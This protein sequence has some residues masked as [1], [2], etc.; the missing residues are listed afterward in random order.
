MRF[1]IGFLDGR[2]L[3]YLKAW[4]RDF[5]AKWGRWGR[6]SGCTGWTITK[7]E[8][9]FGITGLSE[10]LVRRLYNHIDGKYIL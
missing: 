8:I 7:T 9:N 5:E 10:N 6:D 1:A 3:P 4:N 2:D